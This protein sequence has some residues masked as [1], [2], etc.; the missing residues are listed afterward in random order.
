MKNSF[1]LF[2][3][4]ITIFISS[5]V[6]INSMFFTKE[7]FFKQKELLAIEISK[8]DLLSTKLFL[9][10]NKKD[11]IKNLSYEDSTLY[12]DNNILLEDVS[13]FTLKSDSNI[14]EIE[15]LL[16]DSI[17]QIWKFNL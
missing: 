2:E 16:K 3:L 13:N 4:I 12:F 11:L 14:I 1:S 7:L 5:F 17:K 8:I 9:Q 10:L 15:I 6:I